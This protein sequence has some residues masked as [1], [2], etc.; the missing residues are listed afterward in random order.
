MI[1]RHNKKS[2]GFPKKGFPLEPRYVG[3]CTF[4]TKTFETRAVGFETW[5]CTVSFLY[6]NHQDTIQELRLV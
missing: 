3:M 4:S 6:Q 2:L 1:G 5:A